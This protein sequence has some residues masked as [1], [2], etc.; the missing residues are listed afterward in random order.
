MR[1]TQEDDM[2]RSIEI[3]KLAG[4]LMCAAGILA[5]HIGGNFVRPETVLYMAY[6]FR[7]LRNN[8]EERE[9]I[10]LHLVRYIDGSA[11][12]GGAV[13]DAL[14]ASD[15]FASLGQEFVERFLVPSRTA[16]LVVLR[17]GQ[18][19]GSD[20]DILC[21]KRTFYPFGAALP[22]G[23]IRED[24]EFNSA[25]LPPDVFAAL[26]IA[27]EKVLGL[28]AKQ[29]R[30]GRDVRTD[31]R[32]AYIVQGEGDG[33]SVRMFAEDEGGYRFRENLRFV[34][35][36]SDPRHLVDTIGFR[37]ELVGEPP[38]GMVWRSHAS[39]LASDELAGGFAFGHHREIV[40]FIASQTSVE[41]ERGMRERDFVRS[42]VRDPLGQYEI[43]RNR[44]RGPNGRR[45]SFPELFPVVDRL[46]VELF[47]DEVNGL[48]VETPLLAGFRDKAV[49]SLR[50]VALK[51]RAFCPYVSMLRAIAEAMAFLDVV[52]R[53]KR[54]WYDAAPKDRIIEHNPRTTPFASYHMYR[55]KYRLDELLDLVP[56]EIVIPTFESLSATDLLRVRC[57]PIR[58]VGLS[59]DFLYVDEF[60]QS[61]E[62][63]GMH[64]AN[65]AWRMIMEDRAVMRARRWS[66]TRLT[67]ES[68]RFSLDYLDRIRI[69]ATDSE[70][71]REVKKLKKIIIFEITHEDARPFLRD[72]ICRYVQLKEGGSV[73]FEVPR[74]DPRTGYMDVVDTRDT[75]ISTLAY[76]RCK[77]QHGFYDHVDAQLPQIVDPRYRTAE[78]IARAA[79]ELLAELNAKPVPEAELDAEGRVS[80]EWLLRRTC[81][82]GPDNIHNVD[83]VD[84]AVLALGDGATALNPKRYL[85]SV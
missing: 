2:E 41:K 17:A 32:T 67:E 21:G 24:D 66:R 11:E 55:Y 70:R 36:P 16:D 81:A 37:C 22:G 26:R 57:V 38:A 30:Y 69:R 47:R 52:A 48:C 27:A 18:E 35:R 4:E 59:S 63:F 42:L 28:D 71:D 62:E 83:A 73:P 20:R 13:A 5:D 25:D 34:L 84:P 39:I 76:V 79:Y 80:Y 82:V 40:A 53:Q 78:W 12:D 14:L 10:R 49:I 56:E 46:L 33:P 7:R 54:R 31:G 29:A 19:D 51:N 23:F 65:H 72:I 6:W 77:L 44:F 64:D 58:F 50:H 45:A 8:H 68:A 75:G 9:R 43:L 15:A 61:P 85:A 3:R 1:N 60:E 74:V